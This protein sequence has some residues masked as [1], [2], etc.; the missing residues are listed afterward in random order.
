VYKDI[1]KAIPYIKRR[2]EQKYTSIS[3]FVSAACIELLDKEGVKV[4]CCQ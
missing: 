3:D 1:E 2:N 4:E